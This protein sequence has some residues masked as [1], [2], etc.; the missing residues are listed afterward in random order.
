MW[1]ST[2]CER[3][4]ILR[5]DLSSCHV[6]WNR[7]ESILDYCLEGSPQLILL[8]NTM[9]LPHLQYCLVTWGNFRDDRN[10]KLRDRILRLQKCFLRVI[11]NTHRL[12]HADPLFARMG[13]LKIDDLYKQ[14]VR[15]LSFRLMNNTLPT[16]M[17]TLASRINHSHHT[18]GSKINLAVNSSNHQSLNYILPTHWNSLPITL[19]ESKSISSFK[20][21][22][23]KDLLAPYSAFKCTTRNCRSCLPSPLRTSPANINPN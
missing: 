13:S 11:Y 4:H 22:S 10:L 1:T 12:S 20:V 18:R 3:D 5:S 17:A 8:D 2:I 7:T 21:N 15:C 14:T 9:V 19:K 23:K 16:R 6:E